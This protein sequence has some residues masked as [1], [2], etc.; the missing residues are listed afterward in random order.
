V[1]LAAKRNPRIRGAVDEEAWRIAILVHW[2]TDII[3]AATIGL[4]AADEGRIHQWHEAMVARDDD[5]RPK[6]Q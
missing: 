3:S 2:Q 1:H 4:S 5:I 6:A